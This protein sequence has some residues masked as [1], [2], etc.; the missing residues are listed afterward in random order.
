MS[1]QL[2]VNTVGIFSYSV[3]LITWCCWGLVIDT[4]RG[5]H[6]IGHHLP[7]FFAGSNYLDGCEKGQYDWNTM[8]ITKI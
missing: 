2:H 3:S 5:D 1:Q 8:I 6:A 4:D 7:I